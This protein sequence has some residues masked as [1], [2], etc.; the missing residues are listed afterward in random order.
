MH[1]K[2]DSHWINCIVVGL[3]LRLGHWSDAQ[4]EVASLGIS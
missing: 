1:S 4:G 3:L 2:S